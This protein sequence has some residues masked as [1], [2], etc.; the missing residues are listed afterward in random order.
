MII[1]DLLCICVGAIGVVIYQNGCCI[2]KDR[3]M[4]LDD[5]LFLDSPPITYYISPIEDLQS[6]G[7]ED[8]DM[9]WEEISTN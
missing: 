7:V 9:S 1:V 8:S 2:P 5:F 3:Y 4:L 6:V